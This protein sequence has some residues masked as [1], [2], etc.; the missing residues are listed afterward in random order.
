MLGQAGNDDLAI[1]LGLPFGAARISFS[2][3]CCS[4][5]RSASVWRL[6]KHSLALHEE[7]VEVGGKDGEELCPFEQRRAFVQRLGE[8]ALVEVEPAQIT[9]DPHRLQPGGQ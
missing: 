2:R 1:A 6:A 7:L 3:T 8:H 9:V 4:K 5:L